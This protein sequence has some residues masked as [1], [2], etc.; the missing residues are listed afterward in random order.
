V[1][2]D[3]TLVE[4]LYG[5]AFL[6][7]ETSEE[8]TPMGP[9]RIFSLVSNRKQDFEMARFQLA[10]VYSKFLTQKPEHGTRSMLLAAEGYVSSERNRDTQ[11]EKERIFKFNNVTS[12]LRPDY[13]SIWDSGFRTHHVEALKI[14]SSF[15]DWLE[16]ISS[17]G[18]PIVDRVIAILAEKN[19]TALVWRRL[20]QLG[21]RH[22]EN[23]GQK[24]VPLVHAVPILV[25]YD[26]SIAAGEYLEAVFPFLT[27]TQRRE[28]E[29]VILLL[30]QTNTDEKPE[31]S[32][33]VRNRLLGCLPL[34]NVCDA[35]TKELIEQLRTA[36]AIPKNEPSVQ[37][38]EPFF[39]EF[40]EEEYL[41][42]QG[43][44][45]EAEVNKNIRALSSPVTAFATKHA[46]SNPS[47]K[48]VLEVVPLMR[49]L[50]E[51]L[52]SAN[53]K[54][55]HRLQVDHAWGQLTEACERVSKLSELHCSDESQSFVRNTLLEA[56]AHHVPEPH[57]EQDRQFDESPS[58]GGPSA[59]IAA[60]Q[61]LTNLLP[62]R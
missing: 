57:Q 16:E 4:G 40:G 6:Y 31:F 17:G 26:T 1:S 51:A 21:T 36:Q 30:P 34:E 2:H 39:R 44:P 3:P 15:F 32:E 43:V 62:N 19:R 45:V 24:I 37:F 10:E 48:E 28:I 59:R 13:S 42:E 29:H 27:A 20:L 8:R 25:A 14:V 12:S 58:W 46:N 9:S 35:K 56:S 41:R 23:I 33:K 11:N 22:P 54:G 38:T 55:A 50:H 52:E 60:A 61:G 5:A 47:E 18:D 7:Q 49:K 53:A